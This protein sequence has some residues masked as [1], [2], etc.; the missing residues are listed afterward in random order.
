MGYCV[1]TI[2]SGGQ[3]GVDRA[4]LDV[5][6]DWGL[7]VGGWCPRGRRAEDGTIP[8]RYPLRETDSPQYDVRTRRNVRESDGTLVLNCG[9]PVGGTALTISVA[10]QS[11]KPVYIADLNLQPDPQSVIDWLRLHNI[12]VLNIAGPRE[13]TIPGIGEQAAEFLT[14]L[15]DALGDD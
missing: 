7:Q 9:A 4:A 6:L 3:T 12:E 13:S 10:E 14:L 5:A 8:E 11:G 2:V 1:R 15:L